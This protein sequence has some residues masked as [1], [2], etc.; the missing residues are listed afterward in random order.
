MKKYSEEQRVELV[1]EY[2]KRGESS[3]SSIRA[4]SSKRTNQPKVGHH[5]VTNLV[6]KF[7]RTGSVLDDKEG[8]KTAKRTVRTL[9]IIDRVRD[10]HRGD[11]SL[12]T[13]SIARNLDISQPSAH[14][15]LRKDLGLMPYKI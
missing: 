7:E 5:T 13:W 14:R 9:K 10:F 2:Y 4:F 6:N 8:M 11:S 1:K 15:I 3:T 12:S